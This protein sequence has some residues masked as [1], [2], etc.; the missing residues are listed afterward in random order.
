[1][2]VWVL[3]AVACLV[4]LA[5][6][7]VHAADPL[8][9]ALIIGDGLYNTP[10]RMASGLLKGRV[11]VVWKYDVSPFHSGAAIE[12][13]DELLGDKKW[14]LIHFNFGLND[15]MY[16]D[17][18]T[19]SIRAMAKVAGGVRVSSP[20]VYEK[21]LRELVKRFKA[22]GAKLIWASTTP[23]P[24][25]F[26]GILDAGSDIE[27]NKIAAKIMKENKVT[28]NDMHAYIKESDVANKSTNPFS[29]NR[30]PLYPP[31]VRSILT[32]LNLV[33]P[34][35][36]PVKVFIMIGGTAH[37]GAGVIFDSKK[38]RAG[39]KPGSLDDLVLNKETAAIYKHLI[40][41]EGN[42]ATRSDV[43]LQFDHRGQKSGAHGILYGGDRKRCIGPEYAFGHV[44]GNHF[45]QQVL[46]FK[47]A[48]G[49]PSLAKDLR[50]PSSGATG[51]AYKLMQ[52]Q[53]TTAL[54]KMQD[55]FPDYTNKAGYE[56]AG[57]V[58]NL[59][60]ADGKLDKDAKV[61]ADYL[62]KLIADIRKD[63]SAPKLPVVIVATGEGGRKEVAFSAIIKA[64]QA[65]AAL[66]Q[67]KGNV[68]Y[69]ETRDFW[70]I[71]EASPEN[72]AEKWYGN[73]ESFY[74]MGHAIGED[75]LKLLQ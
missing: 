69:T 70:P 73:A 46:I 28:I 6:A 19:K 17:P 20:Q 3:C 9:R 16:K 2:L 50:P 7:P 64:Q 34:V 27:Y 41:K 11:E 12:K 1:M 14:D 48:L 32:E 31:I 72:Y 8:P 42:W 49:N 43:W 55:S 35:K 26:N 37:T 24:K 25:D 61:Y 56:I 40:D 44:L 63:L 38:P 68:I 36:G 33:K 15:L 4:A 60:E 75:M 67:F 39:S 18:A 5:A 59:G 53:I 47:T 45:E 52:T 66:A 29:F 58:L 30:Y 10:S 62:P 13:F 54:A 74:K 23:I 51:A 71:K 21:N 22:T 57:L 65:V